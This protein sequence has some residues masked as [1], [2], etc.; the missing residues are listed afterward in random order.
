MPIKLIAAG[1][2]LSLL[3]VCQT[4]APAQDSKAQV[5]KIIRVEGDGGPIVDLLRPGS[6]VFIQFKSVLGA[7]VIRGSADAVAEA[8]REVHELQALNSNSHDVELTIYVLGGSPDGKGDDTDA[9]GLAPVFKQLHGTFLFKSYQ[10]LSTILMRSG[11][12]S[13]A[14]TQGLMKSP[15][16]TADFNRPGSYKVQFESAAITGLNP[17]SIHLRKLKFTASIPY[18]TGKGGEWEQH[19]IG[20]ETDVDLHEGQKVVVGTSNVEPAGTTLFIVVT[21][22]LL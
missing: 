11:Q 19:D 12:G 7:I 14:L 13:L 2:A 18:A 4:P 17:A 15:D 9:A 5:M 21:A 10:L 8:E 6:R 20:I 16:A 22:R 1:L 3:A